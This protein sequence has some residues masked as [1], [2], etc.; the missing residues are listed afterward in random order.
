MLAQTEQAIRDGVTLIESFNVH[1]GDVHDGLLDAADTHAALVALVAKLQGA[2]YHAADSLHGQI[3][4]S[5]D[6]A[7]IGYPNETHATNCVWESVA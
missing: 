6:Q 5:C 7:Y 2:L 3:C 4:P 1:G